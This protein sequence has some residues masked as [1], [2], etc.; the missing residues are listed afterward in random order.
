LFEASGIREFS[1]LDLTINVL[2]TKCQTCQSPEP[3][4]NNLPKWPNRVFGNGLLKRFNVVFDF[5]KNEVYL[6]RND[7]WATA[8]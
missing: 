1:C 3:P 5:Q 7:F 4:K 2:S 8:F 6:R